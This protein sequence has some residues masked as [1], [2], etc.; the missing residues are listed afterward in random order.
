M[1]PHLVLICAICLSLGI[2]ILLWI[3]RSDVT[4]LGIGNGGS[5]GV[6]PPRPLIA[7][8]TENSTHPVPP[9]ADSAVLKSGVDVPWQFARGTI[10]LG[11]IVDSVHGECRLSP[12]VID[13]LSLNEPEVAA[14][15]SALSATWD[16]WMRLEM[17]NSRVQP[18]GSI[19]IAWAPEFVR[20]QERLSSDTAA[21]VGERRSAALAGLLLDSIYFK[22]SENGAML[23]I[24]NESTGQS[25]EAVGDNLPIGRQTIGVEPGSRILERYGHVIP[26]ELLQG[27]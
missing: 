8:G 6:S 24:L 5:N 20:L 27:E 23:R 10:L 22:S 18:N 14:I 4:A 26:E 15:N 16:D 25:I 9:I 19:S 7:T 12:L 21:I 2:N 11:S 3:N 13:G 17:S 1:R